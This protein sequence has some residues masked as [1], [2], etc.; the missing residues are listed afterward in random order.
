MPNRS[1]GE[2]MKA[3]TPTPQ[4]LCKLGSIAIH[5]RELCSP[6]GHNFDKVALDALL[7]DGDVKAWLEEMDA[8]ALLP[9]ER[10][11]DRA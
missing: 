10:S 1:F 3:L 5:A 4:L 11:R 6:N 2:T 7:D 8:A 9:R